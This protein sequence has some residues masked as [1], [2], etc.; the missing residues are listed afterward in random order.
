MYFRA[1]CGEIHAFNKEFDKSRTYKPYTLHPFTGQ[2]FNNPTLEDPVI[3]R[4]A[5]ENLA[6]IFIAEVAA[7]AIMT[8][9][10]SM[11]SWDIIIRKH[12]D[13]VF[14][15]KRDDPNMLDLLTVNET[16]HENQPLDDESINGVR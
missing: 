7:A 11:F 16:S 12:G 8:A 6:D 14:I 4:L 10:K 13:K 5:K 9:P 15:D 2:V 3:Q 1:K